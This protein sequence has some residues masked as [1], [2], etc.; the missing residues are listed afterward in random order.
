M[1]KRQLLT[2]LGLG[3]TGPLL[4]L[5]AAQQQSTP[6]PESPP[7]ITLHAESRIVLTDVT[8]T[9]HN[10][11][12]VHGL[13]QSAFHISDNN[14]PQQIASF[15]E[16]IDEASTPAPAP[17]TPAGVFSN[18]FS[19]LPPVL[20]VALIDTTNLELPD[21]MYLS[22]QLTK[23][24]NALPAGQLLAVFERHGDT[25]VLLQPFTS[26]HVL[27]LAALRKAM[28]RIVLTGRNY[29]SDTDTLHQIAAY[30]SQVPG[31]KNI[32]WFS[33]GSTFFLLNGLEEANLLAGNTSNP[34]TPNAGVNLPLSTGFSATGEDEGALRQVYDELEA[35]RIAVYPIDARSLT[36]ENDAA[37]KAQQA[38]MSDIA[39]ST[40]G[41]AFYNMNGLA[42][43]AGRIV[44]SDSSAYTITYSPHNFRYDNKWHTVRVTVEGPYHLS[45]RR[46]YFADQ[47]AS[48]VP[49]KAEHKNLEL[50]SGATAAVA[51]DLRA[52]PIVFQADAHPEAGTPNANSEFIPLRPVSS[53][54]KGT[55]AFAVDYTL[56]TSA[57]TPV[58]VDGTLRATVAFAVIALD[59][60]GNRVAQTLDRVRFPLRPADPPKQLKVQQQIDLHKGRSF[61][62]LVVWD[63][64]SG[65][66]GTIEIPVQV[67]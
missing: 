23:F 35:A 8:V 1:F 12:P 20:N 66:I 9:D 53:P 63:A 47:P 11:K 19:H 31:R 21:Q 14:Q 6:P 17:A 30:L 61:L 5:A 65:H 3:I 26:D 4:L 7:T 33:G 51:P 60:N 25:A 44:S 64:G 38:Q 15:E 34:N 67:K 39:Q 32:L 16:H 57:L 40:G 13:P 36:V 42:Q 55:T 29:R 27:L 48:V 24:V 56:S 10:G 50:A 52:S 28:P 41:E 54:G 59:S 43:I 22:F 2:L 49:D 45:Y 18:D 62:A 58:E 37:L 46:G